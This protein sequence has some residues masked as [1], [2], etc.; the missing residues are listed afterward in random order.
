MLKKIVVATDGSDHAKKAIDF[1]SDIASRYEAKMYII[2][3]VFPLP[4]MLR[5]YDIDK[6][7]ENQHKVAEE[8]IASA[9]REVKKKGLKDYQ[10]LMLDGDPAQEIIEFA[11]SQGVDMII[12]GSHGAGRTE[13]LLLGSVSHKVCHLADCTCVTV[14]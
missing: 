3:V 12:M 4:S 7:E 1:A 2:H 10:S 6:I 9:E 8:I 13:M 11:R 14:K 5:G